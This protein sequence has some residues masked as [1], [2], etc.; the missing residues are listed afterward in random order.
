[1]NSKNKFMRLI[2]AAGILAISICLTVIVG[3]S[4]LRHETL[5]QRLELN[6]AMEVFPEVHVHGNEMG[7]YFLASENDSLQNCEAICLQDKSCSAV[8][9]YPANS[10]QKRSAQC[11]LF[12]A[13]DLKKITLHNPC[14]TL[15]IRG[16]QREQV[17]FIQQQILKSSHILEPKR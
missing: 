6:K 17:A 7:L 15:A 10:A 1:M 8:N 3:L 2:A 12:G 16:N 13:L 11:W 9:Y 14:C 5:L 4:L